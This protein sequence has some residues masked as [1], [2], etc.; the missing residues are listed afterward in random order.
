M[1]INQL[2]PVFTH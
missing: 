1:L 2:I